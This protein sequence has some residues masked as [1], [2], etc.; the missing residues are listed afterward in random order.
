MTLVVD[1]CQHRLMI[2]M[3]H[4][5]INMCGHHRLTI[6]EIAEKCNISFGSCQEVFKKKL[7]MRRIAAKFVPW[8][9]M[10]DQNDILWSQNHN[11]WRNM[12][13]RLTCSLNSRMLRS[14]WLVSLITT[15]LFVTNSF[16]KG[17]Q[18]V[19]FIILKLWD[20]CLS[21]RGKRP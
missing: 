14:C 11:R 16:G 2:V 5:W 10:E 8:I 6:L 12:G 4:E 19:V 21:V 13:L 17:K 1:D 3:V 15:D 9:M 7:K 18:A 20:D